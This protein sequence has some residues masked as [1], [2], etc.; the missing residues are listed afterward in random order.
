MEEQN[1]IKLN[2]GC[3]KDYQEGFINIDCLQEGIKVDVYHNLKTPLPYK[4]NSVDCV[5]S[6]AILEH[7][8]MYDGV[9]VFKDWCRILKPGGE[10]IVKVPNVQSIIEAKIPITEKIYLLYGDPKWDGMDL[11]DSGAHKWGFTEESLISLF[12]ENDLKVIDIKYANLMR[13][14]MIVRGI[15]NELGKILG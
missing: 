6:I 2:L 13:V 8:N 3:G 9:V 10:L 14:N 7:F 11:G 1:K 15:K 12:K 5:R 4:D